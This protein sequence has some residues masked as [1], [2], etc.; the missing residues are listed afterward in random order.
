MSGHP[1]MSAHIGIDY[2]K[3]VKLGE[4]VQIA[5]WITGIDRRKVHTYG[6]LRIGGTI[7]TEAKGLFVSSDRHAWDLIPPEI[8]KISKSL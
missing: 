7:V 2:R 4:T 3:P 1:V 8:S 6:E 5:A